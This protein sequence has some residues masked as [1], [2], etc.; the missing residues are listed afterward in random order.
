[1]EDL[2]DVDEIYE[3]YT[4][5]QP[6]GKGNVAPGEGMSLRC[7]LAEHAFNP[8]VLRSKQQKIVDMLDQLPD[9]FRTGDGES[10][11]LLCLDKYGRTWTKPGSNAC[12]HLMAMAMALG[13][14]WHTS[15]PSVWK[16]KGLGVPNIFI[17]NV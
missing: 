4:Q 17:G 14:A 5:C 12:E 2:I 16:N 10:Y 13:L 3:L 1:M 15:H 7:V 9:C 6:N 11:A 8:V